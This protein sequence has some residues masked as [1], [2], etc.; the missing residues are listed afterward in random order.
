MDFKTNVK[1][2]MS[3]IWLRILLFTG[4]RSDLPRSKSKDCYEERLIGR[5][6]RTF[7][8]IAENEEGNGPGVGRLL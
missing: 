1:I 7:A 4:E 8:C 5:G 3:M 6:G 2:K